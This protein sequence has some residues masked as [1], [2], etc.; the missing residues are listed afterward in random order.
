MQDFNF[1]RK[2]VERAEPGRFLA[3]HRGTP[4]CSTTPAKRMAWLLY[5]EGLVELVQ[6]RMG[7]GT[8]MYYAVKRR[9]KRDGTRTAR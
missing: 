4:S 9:R 7:D 6:Q 3:Y 1:T 8:F 5:E 2:K